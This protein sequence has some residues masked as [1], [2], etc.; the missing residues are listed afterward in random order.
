MGVCFCFSCL[1]V[2]GVSFDVL[3]FGACELCG[4]IGLH[5]WS[6]LC[7]V[8]VWYEV[9]IAAEFLSFG[10]FLVCGFS[11]FVFWCWILMSVYS[12]VNFGDFWCFG[13]LLIE[14]CGFY[15]ICLGVLLSV[16]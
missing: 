15:W 2:S 13:G 16:R 3:E 10:N 7:I 14:Y 4:F 6:E 11:G 1:D 5:F 12:G 9:G 8:W